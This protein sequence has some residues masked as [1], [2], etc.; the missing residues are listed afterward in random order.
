MRWVGWR[1]SGQVALV[2]RMAATKMKR[3]SSMIRDCNVIR[4]SG[5]SKCAQRSSNVIRGVLPET[6]GLNASDLFENTKIL[7]ELEKRAPQCKRSE[8]A[9]SP[10]H[11]IK[12]PRTNFPMDWVADIRGIC[13]PDSLVPPPLTCRTPPG[14]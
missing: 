13:R 6:S 14:L 10:R 3:D 4:S 2:E 11:H 1:Q 7:I 12:W 8:G 9:P 5:G